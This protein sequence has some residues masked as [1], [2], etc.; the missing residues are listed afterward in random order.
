MLLIYI[1]F[2]NITIFNINKNSQYFYWLF[3]NIKM[4]EEN[5]YLEAD[6]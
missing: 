2:F 4:K 3:P 5:P 6:L 1:A